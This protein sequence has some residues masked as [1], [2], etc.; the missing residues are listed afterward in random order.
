MNK[1]FSFDFVRD[2][3]SVSPCKKLT[4]PEKDNCFSLTFVVVILVLCPV[5]DCFDCFSYLASIF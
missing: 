2:V 5:R 3:C 4:I 1:K